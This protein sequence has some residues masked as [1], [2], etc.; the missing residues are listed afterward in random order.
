MILADFERIWEHRH[1]KRINRGPICRGQSPICADAK[2]HTN[3]R[4][5]IMLP[6][7]NFVS[8]FSWMVFQIDNAHEEH[9]PKQVNCH[10][11]LARHFRSSLSSLSAFPL[12]P[13]L[14]PRQIPEF[15][16]HGYVVMN[17]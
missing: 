15:L 14:L 8:A 7:S 12:Y 3:T 4:Q 2:F 17:F 5:H 10:S 6:R 1:H 13:H 9:L 11:S 16:L